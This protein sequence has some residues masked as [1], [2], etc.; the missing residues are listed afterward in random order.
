MPS[1]NQ[2]TDTPGNMFLFYI[3][4][5]MFQVMDCHV[6]RFEPRIQLEIFKLG[7]ESLGAETDIISLNICKICESYSKLFAY[8]Q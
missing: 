6:I 2:H 5:V 3:P 4:L 8:I 7:F 1:P